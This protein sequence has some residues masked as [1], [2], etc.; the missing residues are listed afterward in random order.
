MTEKK[1]SGTPLYMSP[2][3]LDNSA[4]YSSQ[5]ADIWALGV[6]LIVLL[7]AKHP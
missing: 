3:S 1:Q 2:E 7:T 4:D 6:T 5:A